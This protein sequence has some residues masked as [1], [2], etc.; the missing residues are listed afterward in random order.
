MRVL[1]NRMKE[2]EK[3]RQQD[4]KVQVTAANDSQVSRSLLTTTCEC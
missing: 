2:K 1:C 3:R 4:K